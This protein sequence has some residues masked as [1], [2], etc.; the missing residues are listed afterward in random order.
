M[1]EIEKHYSVRP[2][3][4]YF[5]FPFSTLTPL[6]AKEKTFRCTC[7]VWQANF[8]FISFHILCLKQ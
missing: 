6:W 4:L 3:A 2:F 1:L 8:T 7:T 5:L